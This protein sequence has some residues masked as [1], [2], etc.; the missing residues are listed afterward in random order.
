MKID[1]VR[2]NLGCQ[3]LDRLH[4]IFPA[5]FVVDHPCL[6]SRDLRQVAYERLALRA[7]NVWQASSTLPAS[8]QSIS[9][10]ECGYSSREEPPQIGGGRHGGL[11]AGWRDMICLLA[12]SVNAGLQKSHMVVSGISR[13]HPQRDGTTASNAQGRKTHVMSKRGR[14]R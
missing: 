14:I 13:P 1:R 10:Q 2:V 6:V 12:L 3:V 4:T 9:S 7:R 5:H 8:N 11:A